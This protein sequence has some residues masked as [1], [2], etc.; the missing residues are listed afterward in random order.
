MHSGTQNLP[1]F[2]FNG[3]LSSFTIMGKLNNICLLNY[4]I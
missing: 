3:L 1:H 4:V 2:T